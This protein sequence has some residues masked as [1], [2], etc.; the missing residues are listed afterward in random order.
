MSLTS[1]SVNR[2][3]A[4]PTESHVEIW[5]LLNFS[6]GY[7]LKFT[8]PRYVSCSVY[9]PEAAAPGCGGSPTTKHEYA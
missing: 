9:A 5:W 8:P 1:V 7:V 3:R 4:S 2:K 6:R